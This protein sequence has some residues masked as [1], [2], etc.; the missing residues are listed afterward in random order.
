[1]G[2]ELSHLPRPNLLMEM[3]VL[4]SFFVCLWLCAS[5][6]LNVVSISV[7][8]ESSICTYFTV[9]KQFLFVDS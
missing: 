1:M 5:L 7:S 8:L 4:Q 2:C 6:E 3:E 9:Y